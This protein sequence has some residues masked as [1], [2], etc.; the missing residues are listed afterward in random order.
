MLEVNEDIK[1]INKYLNPNNEKININKT[2]FTQLINDFW[3]I[4]D[5]EQEINE[6]NKKDRNNKNKKK[7]KIKK[8]ILKW[9]LKIQKIEKKKIKI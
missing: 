4:K 7:K 1:T 6:I 3:F 5:F 8:Q 2:S 9:N